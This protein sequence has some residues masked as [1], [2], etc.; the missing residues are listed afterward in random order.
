MRFGRLC[1]RLR[2]REV[3]RSHPIGWIRLS[4]GWSLGLVILAV[5]WIDVKKMDS[6]LQDKLGGMDE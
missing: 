3:I 5:S 1:F 2:P 4:Y 6:E